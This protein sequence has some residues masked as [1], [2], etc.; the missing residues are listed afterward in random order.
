VSA[1]FDRLTGL[2]S[3]TVGE[4]KA[5]ELVQNAARRAQIGLERI[6]CD[7]ALAILEIIAEEPGLIGITA[8]FAKSRAAL[9][10]WD[11]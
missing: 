5:R 1:G 10:E 9:Q 8:R 4:P 7:D 6:T 3:R 2:L 11:E